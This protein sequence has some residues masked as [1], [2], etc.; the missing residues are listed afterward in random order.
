ME[1]KDQIV[2]GCIPQG[3][4]RLRKKADF[5]VGIARN[6]PSGAK[7]HSFSGTYDTAEAVPF[8]NQAFFRSLF[9]P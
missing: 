3:L 6:L 5:S 4:N 1:N 2:S 8:Q 9:G 7:A